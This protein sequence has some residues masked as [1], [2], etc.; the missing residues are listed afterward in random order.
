[1]GGG[2]SVGGGVWMGTTDEEGVA[3]VWRPH[4]GK[5]KGSGKQRLEPC[6]LATYVVCC[7]VVWHKKRTCGKYT[8]LTGR[9]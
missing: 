5:N 2:G 8:W 7:G 6:G 1:M 3:M 9:R 4:G